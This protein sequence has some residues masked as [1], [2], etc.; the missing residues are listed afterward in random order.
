MKAFFLTAAFVLTCLGALNAQTNIWNDYRVDR[1]WDIGV[2]YGASSITRPLGPEK[3]YQGTRTNVVP[4]FGIKLQYVVTPHWHL[5]FDLGFRKWES[6]GLWQQPYL[7]GQKLASTETKF[8]IGSPA[9]SESFQLN[10]AIPFYSH[11]KVINR[12]NLYFG[13]TLGLVT[14]VSDG[15]LG[16]SHLNALPDSSYRYVS[17]YNYGAGIGLSFGV[18][19]G[20]TYYFL[21]RWGVNAEIAARYVGMHAEKVNGLSDDHGTSS[22][23]MM[24]YSGTLGMRYRF[25]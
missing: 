24:F 7:M 4:E 25:R 13:A 11:Y 1:S 8:G 23:H 3:A 17:S 5:A 20:Y 18:Q 10:Y 21:R 14:T 12:A 15:N 6:F 9:I 22:Y 2:D 19:A 16:Y